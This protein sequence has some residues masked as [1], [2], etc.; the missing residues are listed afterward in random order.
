LDGGAG[1]N[2]GENKLHF[3]PDTFLAEREALSIARPDRGIEEDVTQL[4]V[5]RGSY[6]QIKF[7]LKANKDY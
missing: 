7:S 1:D 2:V 3:S 4:T 5:A 6:L